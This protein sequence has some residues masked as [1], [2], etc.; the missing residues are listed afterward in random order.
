MEGGQVAGD[1]LDRLPADDLAERDDVPLVVRALNRRP[2]LVDFDDRLKAL[3][4]LGGSTLRSRDAGAVRHEDKAVDLGLDRDPEPRGQRHK[5]LSE[6]VGKDH[7]VTA[8]L[9]DGRRDTVRT[10]AIEGDPLAVL[11]DLDTFGEVLAFADPNVQQPVDDQMVDLGDPTVAFDPQVVDRHLVPVGTE[12][13]LDLVGGVALAAHAS[14][15]H[16]DLQFDPMAGR[17]VDV[18][19]HEERLERVDLRLLVAGRLDQHELPNCPGDDVRTNVDI[20]GPP[21]PTVRRRRRSGSGSCP[22]GW[23]ALRE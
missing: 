10:V 23:S 14:P 8:V 1:G 5:T 22:P 18:G 19:S 9:L 3:D 16:P 6:H 15:D 7:D 12:V 13:E 11:V 21:S 4:A 2:K 17:P 20:V